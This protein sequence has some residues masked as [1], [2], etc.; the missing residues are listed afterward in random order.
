M[1][2]KV[3]RISGLFDYF[4]YPNE[5]VSLHILLWIYI[6]DKIEKQNRFE[7]TDD[8]YQASIINIP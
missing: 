2:T 8:F 4:V 5:D 3:A 7:K 6:L 1:I